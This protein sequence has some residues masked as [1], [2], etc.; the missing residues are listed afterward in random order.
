[1]ETR[2]KPITEH[3]Q[4][5]ADSTPDKW[6]LAWWKRQWDEVKRAYAGANHRMN[7]CHAAYEDVRV[8]A[9]AVT[10]QCLAM[11]KRCET[12]EAEVGRLREQVATLEVAI[13]KARE[14][15]AALRKRN[16]A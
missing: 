5:V 9:Q 13:E 8:A 15:Y 1:M 10:E 4:E 7:L 11:E 12:M 14:A 2:T 3:F 6:T 16:D